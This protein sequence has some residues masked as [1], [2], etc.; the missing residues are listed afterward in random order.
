MLLLNNSQIDLTHPFTLPADKMRCG[1]VALTIVAAFAASK[2]QHYEAQESTN[3]AD[4]PSLDSVNVFY[5]VLFMKV[6]KLDAVESQFY[7]GT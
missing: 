5:H 2:I 7:T 6:E 1:V 4:A 3:L